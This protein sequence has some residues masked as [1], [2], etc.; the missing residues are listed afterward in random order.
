M[1]LQRLPKLL[2]LT[3]LISVGATVASAQWKRLGTKEVD[4]RADHDTINVS[5]LRGD[6]KAVKISVAQAPVE[7]QRVVLTYGNGRTEEI[8]LRSR[9]RAG[10]ESRVIDLQG[11]DRVI[12]KVDFWYESPRERRK[13]AK[14]TLWGRG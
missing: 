7:F 4:Y 2:L 14:V 6:F 11:R 8:E 10:G 3:I 13:K 9:I 12:R 5:F 1:S